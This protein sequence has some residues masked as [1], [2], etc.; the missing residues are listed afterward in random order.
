MKAKNNPGFRAWFYFRN[1]WSMYFAFILA[2]INTLTVT[3]Y[4]AIEKMPFLKIIF[5]TFA[6]YIMLAVSIGI[7]LL[8]TIGYLHY[9][10]SAAHKAE[11]DVSMETDHYRSRFLVNSELILMLQLK[12]IPIIVKIAKNEK[13]TNEEIKDIDNMQNMIKE[14]NE[15]RTFKNKLDIKFMKEKI[16]K[17]D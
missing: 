16:S 12:I 15:N 4:L 6:V 5:P 3:Y 7:P 8:V 17:Q 13:I 9:K 1:G 14:H 11:I 2:A 10:R